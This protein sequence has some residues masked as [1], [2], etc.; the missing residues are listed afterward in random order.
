MSGI[1]LMGQLGEKRKSQG[2]TVQ[3]RTRKTSQKKFNFPKFGSGSIDNKRLALFLVVL[4]A[5]LGGKFY[6]DEIHKQKLME[7]Q[8]MLQD[9]T[10]KLQ[11]EQS[12]AKTLEDISKAMEDYEKRVSDLRSKLSAFERLRKNRNLLVRVIDNSI[13][14]MPNDIWLSTLSADRDNGEIKMEGY[15]STHQNI[16]EYLAQLSSSIFFPHWQLNYIENTVGK[17]PA[18][19]S[20][21]VEVPPNSKKFSIASKIAEPN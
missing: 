6:L 16:S 20:S 19:N 7:Q 17:A 11:A 5:F 21:V 13:S 2:Y 14:D 15:S 12:K 10:T 18:A 8:K 1:N 3:K 4:F 9:Y